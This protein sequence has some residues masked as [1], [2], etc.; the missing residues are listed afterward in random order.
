MNP[1]RQAQHAC[2]A[3]CV[4]LAA[5]CAV[6]VVGFVD[7]G[8]R[9]RSARRADPDAG[10]D[11]GIIDGADAAASVFDPEEAQRNYAKT[12]DIMRHIIA[13]TCAAE[14]NE[15]HANEEFPDLSTV[16]NLWT[17]VGLSCN[18]GI[19]DGTTVE[20]LCEEKSDH[21]RITDGV[22]AGY[23]ARIGSVFE[24]TDV[25]GAFIKYEMRVDVEPRSQ[26]NA[27]FVLARDGIEEPG[28]GSGASLV[29]T[30]G[31]LTL[32]VLQAQDL[33]NSELIKQGDRNDNGVYGDGRGVLVR[34]G[35]ARN[36]YLVRRLFG[37]GTTRVRMPLNYNSDNPTEI[38]TP[39]TQ[40]AM[41]VLMS[42]INCIR[43][44]DTAFSELRYDCPENADNDGTW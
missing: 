19:G 39:L 31:S 33:P 23:E 7:A 26:A 18:Q 22:N 24:V 36:S 27:R 30:R 38:N 2:T 43:A 11:A 21:I 34:P 17:L 42:W 9:T 6:P 28:L 25:E 12:T 5:G 16:G 14:N 13:P 44:D 37:R 3:A 29:A 41:Y 32:L 15:C 8:V 20:D 4:L 10:Q 1:G 35:D 40:E